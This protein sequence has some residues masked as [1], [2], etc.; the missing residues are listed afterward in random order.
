MTNQAEI[1][2][3]REWWQ[4]TFGKWLNI[5]VYWK[6][7]RAI[8]TE[9]ELTLSTRSAELRIGPFQF[10]MQSVLFVPL[11][12]S[13]LG[14]S[15]LLFSEV[16]EDPM[17]QMFDQVEES[18]EWPPDYEPLFGIE[19]SKSRYDVTRIGK[20]GIEIMEKSAPVLVSL[21]I[22]MAATLTRLFFRR[23]RDAFPLVIQL[24]RVYLYCVG[25]RLFI[26]VTLYGLFMYVT[27][28]MML[29]E[30]WPVVHLHEPYTFWDFLVL[31]PLFLAWNAVRISIAVW[32]V[33]ALW[34]SS[35]V[36]ANVLQLEGERK[37]RPVRGGRSVAI[38]LFG[39]QLIT[40]FV[41]RLAYGGIFVVYYILHATEW[42][43]AA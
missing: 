35:A 12:I 29:Y 24:D 31:N 14:S 20:R 11:L 32:I 27:E 40:L 25:T 3:A 9:P 16:P 2:P 34:K 43:A 33:T 5:V 39:A 7:R 38:R 37:G 26:P 10:A 22:I 6:T 18:A 15:L 1:S 42:L 28:T 23:W 8:L 19:S 36:I 17:Q 41:A 13:I 4:H 21:A 30:L